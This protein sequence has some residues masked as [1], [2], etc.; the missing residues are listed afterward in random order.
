MLKTIVNYMPYSREFDGVLDSAL[1]DEVRRRGLTARVYVENLTDKVINPYA[2]DDR[3]SDHVNR[4]M[5][6]QIASELLQAG[7]LKLACEHYSGVVKR[8]AELE[9]F[10]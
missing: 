10:R 1:L 6:K 9:I 3:Y 2:T 8:T 4:E 7:K 5:S